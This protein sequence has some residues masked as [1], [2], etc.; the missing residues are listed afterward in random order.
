LELENYA[1]YGSNPTPDGRRLEPFNVVERVQRIEG[2]DTVEVREAEFQVDTVRIDGERVWVASRRYRD[3]SGTQIVDSVW[4]ERWTLHTLKSVR[5]DAAGVTT[6]EFNR[7]QV[8]SV[9]VT[10]DGERQS[11][12]GLHEAEPYSMVG[13]DLVL[14]ALPLREGASGALPV[15]DGR[16]R[17]MDWLRYSV[18]DRRPEARTVSGGFLFKPVYV[19]EVS[20]RG[21][22]VRYWVDGEAKSV[23]RRQLAMA[24]GPP[25]LVVRGSPIPRLRMFPVEPLRSPGARDALPVLR[26]GGPVANGGR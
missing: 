26:Q 17:R 24:E 9:R 8:R 20:F 11:W 4:M 18:T 2:S 7:R 16:G 15:V 6:L 21:Q 10:P 1:F 19:V 12:K 5:R 23:L 14:G 22:T 13:I 3:A 25:L